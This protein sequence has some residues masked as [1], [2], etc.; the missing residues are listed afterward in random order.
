MN[1]WVSI[2]GKVTNNF[3]TTLR[4]AIENS[5]PQIKWVERSYLRRIAGESKSSY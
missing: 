1:G 3:A 5:E 2:L 4:P